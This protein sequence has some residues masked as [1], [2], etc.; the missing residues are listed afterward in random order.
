MSGAFSMWL[1]GRMAVGKTTKRRP[2]SSCNSAGASCCPPLSWRIAYP[3]RDLSPVWRFMII[4]DL[5]LRKT[6]SFCMWNVYFLLV[7]LHLLGDDVRLLWTSIRNWGYLWPMIAMG[8]RA[9]A[10]GWCT[11]ESQVF[12]WTT[13]KN[14]LHFSS[15][16]VNA[17]Q[18]EYVMR[19]PFG[20]WELT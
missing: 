7:A 5:P 18:T 20:G 3:Q 16:N 9:K 13:K 11:G 15:S 10:M 14:L 12:F 6:L 4:C 1:P 8:E 17:K 2:R 19:K